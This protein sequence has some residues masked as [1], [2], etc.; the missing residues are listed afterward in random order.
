MQGMRRLA[1]PVSGRSNAFLLS[2]LALLAFAC[3]PVLAHAGVPNYTDAP[4]DPTGGVEIQER[5]DP[6]AHSS[7]TDGSRSGSVTGE[8][9][10][11][12]DGSGAGSA[13]D[14]SS[15]PGGA[16]GGSDRGNGQGGQGGGS[17]SGQAAPMA[18]APTAAASDDGSSPLIPILIAIA[19]LAAISIGAVLLRQR[20]GGDDAGVPVSP[21]A[22]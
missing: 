16:G 19:V 18:G 9:S 4:P 8:G 6:P 13:D 7:N 12:R 15:G 10:G 2:G 22:G 5:S 3:F 14:K 20:R 17:G 11:D 1:D 21:K